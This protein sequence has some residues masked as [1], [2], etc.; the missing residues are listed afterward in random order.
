MD[1]FDGLR[2]VALV[3]ILVILFC[4]AIFMVAAVV[5]FIKMAIEDYLW[6]RNYRKQRSAQDL[7]VRDIFKHP[8]E[9]EQRVPTKRK[10]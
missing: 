7:V 10:V 9:E 4:F 5:V 3:L 1:G 2:V 8:Y 6:E